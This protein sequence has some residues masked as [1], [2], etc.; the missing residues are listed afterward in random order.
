M[1]S[2][3]VTCRLILVLNDRLSG[4]SD[5]WVVSSACNEARPPSILDVNWLSA[6]LLM[7]MIVRL[8]DLGMVR[9]NAVATDGA[10]HD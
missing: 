7:V 10:R 1:A 2:Q 8:R 6:R 9:R 5:A 4:L 3:E